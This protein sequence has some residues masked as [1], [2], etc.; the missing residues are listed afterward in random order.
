[1]FVQVTV[2]SFVPE[3]H[4]LRSIRSLA[5]DAL[6]GLSQQIGRSYSRTGRPSIP[7]ERLL[8][9]QLLMALYGI[10]SE[11]SFCEQLKYNMLYKWFV[12][13]EL[14][15]TPFAPT[16]FTKNRDRFMA[17]DVGKRLF[18]AI[19]VEASDRGLL[20]SE[21]FSVDG[22]LIEAAASMKSFRSKD[23]DSD[24]DGNGWADFTGAKRGNETHASTT[25]PDSRLMR[26]GLG[27]EAKLSFNLNVLAENR[28]G[29]MVGIQAMIA[30]GRSERVGAVALI[31]G[32]VAPMAARATLGADKG[33][34]ARPFF[35][36][37]TA[38]EFR[39]HIAIKHTTRN[40]PLLDRRTTNS[41]AYQ[42][43]QIFR[44]KIEGVIGWL[45]HP[46]R[47][48]RARLRGVAKTNHL[49]QFYGAAHNM[50]RIVRLSEA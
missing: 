14:D 46:G 28:N 15:E 44:R 3:K 27:K 18:D 35:E 32:S 24:Q 49:A 31:D 37:L 21:H 25:D 33:Y 10:A 48:K 43:S 4:P 41:R 20:S 30:S 2:D 1:M 23:D 13:L 42:L 7:P 50:L 9:S 36:Q 19:V 17:M 47:L 34:D 5:D 16:T 45:K 40:N 12:G 26:K 8:K 39:P 22:T 11:R 38:R 6:K 29:I